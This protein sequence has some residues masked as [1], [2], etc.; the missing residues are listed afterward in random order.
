MKLIR[1]KVYRLLNLE[2]GIYSKLFDYFILLLI[3]INCL[4]IILESVKSYSD[5]FEKIFSSIEVF[6]VIIFSIEIVLRLWSIP[7]K[8][9]YQLAC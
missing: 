1:N 2:L 5:R 6:S 7:E 3:L 9:E 8:K 4:C